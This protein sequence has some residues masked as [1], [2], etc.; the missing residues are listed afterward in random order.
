[1][2]YGISVALPEMNATP[3]GSQKS[4]HQVPIQLTGRKA[5]KG[6]QAVGQVQQLG[7]GSS[8]NVTATHQQSARKSGRL[9]EKGPTTYTTNGEVFRGGRRVNEGK[10]GDVYGK[11]A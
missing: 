8:T 6:N 10:Y 9:R 3:S 2:T 11:Q 7:H 1:M 4:R 5:G